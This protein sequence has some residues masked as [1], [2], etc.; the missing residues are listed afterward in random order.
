MLFR[1]FIKWFVESK[2]AQ[3]L[4]TKYDKFYNWNEAVIYVKTGE[5]VPRIRM[6]YFNI[7][8][9]IVHLFQGTVLVT[10]HLI[11]PS[12]TSGLSMTLS[13]RSLLVLS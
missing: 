10:F 4:G 7:L 6:Y 9:A 1:A 11:H 3:Q 13:P 12:N 5:Y 8:L 2:G